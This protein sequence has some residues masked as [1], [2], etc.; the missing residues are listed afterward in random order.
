MELALS[1]NDNNIRKRYAKYI[2]V[3]ISITCCWR[4]LVINYFKGDLLFPYKSALTS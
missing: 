1:L 4:H 2:D 3:I